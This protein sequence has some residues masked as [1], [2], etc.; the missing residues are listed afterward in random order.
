M[1]ESG[2]QEAVA[3]PLCGVS[4]FKINESGNQEVRRKSV[5]EKSRQL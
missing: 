5:G 2:K 1:T 4:D 3:T